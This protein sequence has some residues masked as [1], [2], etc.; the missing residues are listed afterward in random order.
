MKKIFVMAAA[1][2]FM[3]AVCIPASAQGDQKKESVKTENKDI[4]KRNDTAREMKNDSTKVKKFEAKPA[5]QKADNK[6][7]QSAPKSKRHQANS[8]NKTEKTEKP[9]EQK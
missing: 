9:A 5:V 1:S 2:L 8:A 6:A 4:K 3:T 7:P